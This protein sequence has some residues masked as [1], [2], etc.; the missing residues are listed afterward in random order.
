MEDL[1]K[2]RHYP[3]DDKK[4]A[5]LLVTKHG[6]SMGQ[7]AQVA[8]EPVRR[9]CN[10]GLNSRCKKKAENAWCWWTCWIATLQAGS[11]NAAHGERNSK[12]DQGV[13]NRWVQATVLTKTGEKLVQSIWTIKPGICVS[14]WECTL[15]WTNRWHNHWW[16]SLWWYV[17]N[18]IWEGS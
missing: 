2:R 16:F 5:V 13:F 12:K 17:A 7:T 18:R 9:I 6:Y 4:E 1:K 11:K 14:A 15:I 8:V 10:A 3:E